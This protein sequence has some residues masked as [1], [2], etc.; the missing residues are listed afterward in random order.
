MEE[1]YLE[2]LEKNTHQLKLCISLIT[3]ETLVLY[4]TLKEH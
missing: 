3:N 2:I 1:C 4:N